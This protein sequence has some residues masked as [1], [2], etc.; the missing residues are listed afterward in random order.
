VLAVLF[1]I[2]YFLSKSIDIEIQNSKIFPLFIK[3]VKLSRFE[4]TAAVQSSI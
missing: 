3:E 1:R 4:A 2:F